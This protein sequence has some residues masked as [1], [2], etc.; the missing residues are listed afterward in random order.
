MLSTQFDIDDELPFKV[1]SR[2]S[3]S[4]E[5]RRAIQDD[6]DDLM[7]LYPEYEDVLNELRF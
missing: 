1:E 3:K 4:V 2:P 6:L 5:R 7:D